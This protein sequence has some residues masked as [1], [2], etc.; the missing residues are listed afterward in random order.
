MSL[1]EVLASILIFS[2]GVLG[3]VA[4][5]ARATQVSLASEDR[6]RAAL[7]ANEAVSL[8][9]TNHN[10]NLPAVSPSSVYTTWVAKVA[11]NQNYGLPNGVGSVTYDAPSSIATVT[12]Q[13]QEPAKGS[14]LSQYVTDVV[15][16]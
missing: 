13:W 6:N 12:I 10:G 11:A 14:T 15:V 4:L 1:I 2:I 3:L 9:W 7:L 8:M 5:Q 16:N